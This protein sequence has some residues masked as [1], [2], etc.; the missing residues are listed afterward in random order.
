MAEATQRPIGVALAL[1]LA[2][3]GCAP[4]P[5]PA[6]PPAAIPPVAP[7]PS[8]ESRALARYYANVQAR[9]LSR[10]MLRTDDGGAD[11]AFDARQ[12]AENF[13]RIALYDEY[14]LA[15]GR[16]SPRETPS[17]LRRWE[18]PIRMQ[19]V[20]GE[21]VSPEQRARDRAAVAAHA[22]RLSGISG[23]RIAETVSQPN[24]LVLFLNLD[25]QR[26][27]GPE[28]RRLMPRV[29]PLVV[30]EI[31]NSPRD[32]FC[33]AY[34]MADE[35]DGSSYTGAV[36]LI[37]AEHPDLMRLSCIHEEM[38]QAMGLAN[39]SPQARPSIFNDDEEFALMT[40]HDELLLRILYDRRLR[41]GMTPAAARPMVRRIAEELLAA[42]GDT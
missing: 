5:P 24:F 28:L 35:A 8:A 37:K 19:V 14:V 32:I 30:E 20:F 26:A 42:G 33:V 10:G 23:L 17:R 7:A 11:T 29:S 13:E 4:P 27:I 22:E 1:A 39:D 18:R 6:V 41:A 31:E 9:L 36:V 12:L 2:L 34:A 25:E 38:A 15:R 40:R 3:A 16:F 21:S